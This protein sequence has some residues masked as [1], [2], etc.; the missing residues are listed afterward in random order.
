MNILI[1]GA[2]G[3]IGFHVAKNLLKYRNI[4][5]IGIDNIN[6]YYSQK[7]KLNR[8]K[9]LKKLDKYNKF[10]FFKI[11]LTS[12]KK[13]NKLKKYKIDI[14]IHLAAQAG[15]RHS[16]KKPEDYVKNNLLGFFNILDFSKSLQIKHLL[17]ASTSSVY[18]SENRKC[19]EKFDCNSPIQFY[20]A[21]KK[22]NEVM[23]YS[24]SAIYKLPCTGLRFF[25]VYGPWGRPDM[26]LFKFVKNIKKKKE[27]EVFNYGN[28][29]RDFTYVEDISRSII[30]LIS[31]PARQDIPF[32]IFN[33]GNSKPVKLENFIKEK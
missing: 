28:H 12:Q 14:I 5:I 4:K 33:I 26:A 19:D 13:L 9:Y 10:K 15:V 1:T 27:I 25:T 7:L 23:A 24:Y 22:S 2:A 32:E 17:F 16:I 8:V 3:F 30:K 11:D 20:A 31:K 29:Q 21:T 18:G 6:N